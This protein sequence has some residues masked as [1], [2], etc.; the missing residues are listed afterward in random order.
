MNKLYL[1]FALGLTGEVFTQDERGPG[2]D[3]SGPRDGE[4]RD[5]G[6]GKNGGEGDYDRGSCRG[7]GM[8]CD[9]CLT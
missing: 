7:R 4:G 2:R 6:D 5:G 1:L 3:E 8:K 9:D